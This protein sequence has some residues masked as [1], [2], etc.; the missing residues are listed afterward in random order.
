[1]QGS[2]HATPHRPWPLR[3]QLM[4]GLGGIVLLAGQVV[5]EVVRTLETQYLHHRLK[6]HS[7]QMLSMLAAASLD[8]I[9]SE[10]RPVLKTMVTQSV[11]RDPHIVVVQ[12]ENESG[13]P[14]IAWQR[15]DTS[16]H[17]SHLT[18]TEDITYEG[19]RFGHIRIERDVRD[20]QTDITAHVRTMRLFTIGGLLALGAAI[21][22][23]LHRLVTYPLQQ[24]HHRLTALSTGE[25]APQQTRTTA[26]ELKDLSASVDRLAAALELNRQREADL[27]R[28]HV[29]LQQERDRALEGVRVKNEFLA[30]MS[31]ELRTPLHGILGFANL[32]LERVATANPER[33]RN[34]FTRILSSGDRLLGLLND[35]LDLAKLEAGNMTFDFQ[36]CNLLSLCAAVTDE[37]H[38][39]F[40]ERSLS[41]HFTPTPASTTAVVDQERFRQV[42]RN[43]LSNAVKFSPPGGTITLRLCHGEAALSVSV[44]DQGPGIPPDELETI[45]EK[46]TQSSLTQTGAGG[47]GLGLAICRGIIA[48]HHGHI[49]AKNGP[50]SGAELTVELPI[51]TDIVDV[52]TSASGDDRLRESMPAE[53]P[54]GVVQG[55]AVSG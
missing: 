43:L 5:G 8:A 45:F 20:L 31:D 55:G 30:N 44:R 39:L 37:F 16:P 29:L 46:F 27:Q 9:I 1:M 2:P 51:L 12:V 23:W 36:P 53:E 15:D 28:A 52:T 21:I 13:A 25:L 38:A 32:G 42:L 14:L 40:S 34:Y 50:D 26:R 17:D 47:T 48:A 11:R 6:Q 3:R 4:L 7:Q 41:L 49:W 24:I 18:F 10:D 54:S 19:E 33:L 22:W 35:L